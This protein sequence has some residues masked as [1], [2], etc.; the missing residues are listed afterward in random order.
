M[1]LASLL[2]VT[3]QPEREWF[4]YPVDSPL[5]A[6]TKSPPGQPRSPVR[7]RQHEEKAASGEQGK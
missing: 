2:A 4:L 1:S 6:A 5:P 7:R 3:P